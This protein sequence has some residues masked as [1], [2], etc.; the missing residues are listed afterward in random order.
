ME[1]GLWKGQPLIATE[2]AKYYPFEK[3]VRKASGRK[4]LRCPDPDCQHPNLRYCH[5]EKKDAYF[6]HLNNKHCDYA[7]FDKENTQ[8]MRSVR[9]IIYEH[10]KSMG[11]QVRLEVKVLDGAF[12]VFR[13]ATQKLFLN[14][15][16]AFS[17]VTCTKSL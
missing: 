8:I 16:M 4:E 1:N 2:I 10:F 11:Y 14:W 5:G 3:E 17:T 6:A 13:P 9:K 15:L 7:D 12:L